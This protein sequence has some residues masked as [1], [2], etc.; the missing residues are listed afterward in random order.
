MERRSCDSPNISV[1]D[2]KKFECRTFGAPSLIPVRVHALTGVAINC[3][4]SGPKAFA[5]GSM[6]RFTDLIP[7]IAPHESQVRSR[8]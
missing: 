4:P 3:R 6:N 7:A 1:K 5:F 2:V 8:I